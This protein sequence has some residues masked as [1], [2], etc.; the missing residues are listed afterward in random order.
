MGYVAQIVISSA[1]NPPATTHFWLF[2][3]LKIALTDAYTR[4]P[5]PSGPQK[6][7]RGNRMRCVPKWVNKVHRVQKNDV[8]IDLA[9]HGMP[10]RVFL[11]RFQLVVARFGPPESPKPLENGLFCDQK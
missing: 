8:Q 10:K 7:A 4:V 2:P 9:P 5:K 1:P 6:G 3:P 11:A